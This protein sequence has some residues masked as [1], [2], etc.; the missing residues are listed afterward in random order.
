LIDGQGASSVEIAP[1]VYSTFGAGLTIEG[2]A[3]RNMKEGVVAGLKASI[4]L[5]RMALAPNAQDAKGVDVLEGDLRAAIRHDLGPGARI[6]TAMNHHCDPTQFDL[7]QID[8]KPI[9]PH[10]PHIDGARRTSD[11]K[12]RSATARGAEE[13][14]ESASGTNRLSAGSVGVNGLPRRRRRI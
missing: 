2:E 7:H 1:R 3:N 4:P 6:V 9:V 11:W 8:L 14:L 5:D 10:Y 12:G 13:R